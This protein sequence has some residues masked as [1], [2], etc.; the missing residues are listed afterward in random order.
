[1]AKPAEKPTHV[2]VSLDSLL[3]MR[4]GTLTLMDTTFAF[5]V[6]TDERYYTREEDLFASADMG[7]LTK[8]TFAHVHETL[9]DQ[10]VR[11]SIR[12]R[13]FE[14]LEQL[15]QKLFFDALGTPFHSQVGI[16]VNTYP[17]VLDEEEA[18]LT[19]ESIAQLL[20]GRFTV[21]LIHL[22][23]AE[24]TVTMA[25]ERYRAMVMYS[26]HEW[27]NLHDEEVRKKTLFDRT[28]LY[29]PRLYQGHV[30][31]QAE[32]QEFARNNTEPFMLLEKVLA[33]FVT[34][35]YLPAA[36]FSAAIPSNKP[37]YAA[38]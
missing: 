19:L 1:M 5:E 14:F 12:T 23:P 30:P 28:G 11:N 16:E 24:L 3:D 7:T 33:P 4:L 31:T 34:I 17:Y 38:L 9:R 37:E 8:K 27:L 35:Q 32:L 29:V 6:S 26:Y 22:S 20:D 2:Y 21:R 18:A 13:M 25:A 36:L 15:M 10:V